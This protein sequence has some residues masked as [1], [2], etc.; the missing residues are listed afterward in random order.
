MAMMASRD[1]APTTALEHLRALGVRT[2]R[3]E[4]NE[5]RATKGDGSD[6]ESDD[7][8]D[9]DCGAFDGPYVLRCA[10]VGAGGLERD[11]TFE[12]WRPRR[13][14][15]REE[16]RETY[17]EVY[18]AAFDDPF[19][20][21]NV[22][23][24]ARGDGVDYVG[25]N[26]THAMSGIGRAFEREFP[27]SARQMLG[28][29]KPAPD[30]GDGAYVMEL[31]PIAG[32]RVIDLE[33]RLHKYNYTKH[34]VSEY[35][36]LEDPAVRAAINAKQLEAFAS[37][38]R[39][40]Q[41]NRI[42]AARR[43]DQDSIASP[44]QMET[45]I[46]AATA[47][48]KSRNDLVIEAGKKRNIPAHNLEATEVSMAY[49]VETTPCYA[50]FSKLAWKELLDAVKADTA[51]SSET[52]EPLTKAMSMLL[53]GG[54]SKA[55]TE[56]A[57]LIMF[58]D[59]LCK[60]EKLRK[61]RI[62]EARPRKG[63][64]GE[65]E[66]K[67][68]HPFLYASES[69]VDPNLQRAIIQEFMEEDNSGASRAFVLSKAARDLLRLQILLIALRAYGWT[70]KLDIME[71]Q[72]NI[73]SKELQ[74]YTRQLGCKSASGG[75]NPSVKLDLQG[76]PLAAFLPEIRARAKRAKAKE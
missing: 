60:L 26:F 72:L 64:D 44:Q 33:A 28:R 11:V 49:P 31:I 29:L 4:V 70:L 34:G 50:L 1:D 58:S 76:K 2:V 25:K 63:E 24:C 5:R 42:N 8:S 56:Q 53:T 32:G 47:N 17:R 20:A 6:G 22:V 9:D 13:G 7:D 10:A 67:P 41:V 38:K 21:N 48:M 55:L 66:I 61:G 62:M 39:K 14:L 36:N 12:A 73:D 69:E 68:K 30:E 75:K 51:L 65:T 74:S 19:R 59:A 71:A 23:M 40:R 43:L 37:D 57:K 15:D 35:A 16:M 45:H 27:N 18:E 46:S 54:N 3:F 52:Y